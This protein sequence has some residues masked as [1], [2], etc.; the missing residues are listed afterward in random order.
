MNYLWFGRMR[1][2]KAG[3]YARVERGMLDAQLVWRLDDPQI[4]LA[5]RSTLRCV[6]IQQGQGVSIQAIAGERATLAKLPLATEGR[7]PC[8][9]REIGHADEIV[10]WVA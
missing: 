4:G 6:L 8:I 7:W 10:G 3:T 1:P 2:T 5:A 9:V